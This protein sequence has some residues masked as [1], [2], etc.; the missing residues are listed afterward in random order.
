MEIPFEV[1]LSNSHVIDPTQV[2][3]RVISIGANGI[4]LNSS[5]NNRYAIVC[6]HHSCEDI[7]VDFEHS[8]NFLEPNWIIWNLWERQYYISAK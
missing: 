2:L 8:I 6:Q 1:K 7:N 4:R 3:V 5:Y